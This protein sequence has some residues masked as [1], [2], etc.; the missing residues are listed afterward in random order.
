MN[1][2]IKNINGDILIKTLKKLENLIK[3]HSN[4]SI[5]LPDNKKPPIKNI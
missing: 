4:L 1:N 3:N 2:E 5:G